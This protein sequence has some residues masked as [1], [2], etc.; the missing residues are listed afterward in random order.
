MKSDWNWLALVI[1]PALTCLSACRLEQGG[2]APLSEESSD[3]AEIIDHGDDPPSDRDHYGMDAGP[4]HEGTGDGCGDA[5]QV[6]VRD[7]SVSHADFE[8]PNGD[9]KDI[10]RDRLGEGGKPIY[11]GAPVT[12]TTHGEP[13]FDQWYRDVPGVN[14]TFPILIKLAPGEDGSL[15]YDNAAYF[16]ID[17]QGFGNEGNN[18][19]FHFTSEVHTHF[20]YTGGESFTFTGDDDLFAFINRRL[21]I[22]LGGLH[23][24]ETATIYLDA[25][26]ADLGLKVGERYPLDLFGAE[27]HTSGSHFRIETTIRCF[28]ATSPPK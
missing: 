25:I 19:N 23:A 21:V 24:A 13:L 27:R 17:N 28:T 6:I 1:A 15:S 26:A 9:D 4:Q 16:P 11:A 8:G 7:F 2:L 5:L 10:V 20:E 22:N 14:Q 12:K 18:H 3:G